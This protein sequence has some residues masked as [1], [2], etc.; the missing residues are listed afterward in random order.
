[1][2][3]EIIKKM[4][5]VTS[6]FIMVIG[7]GSLFVLKNFNS[8]LFEDGTEL[9]GVICGVLFGVLMLIFVM[10]QIMKR[11]WYPV[12]LKKLIAFS[13]KQLRIYHGAISIFGLAF[14]IIHIG[15]AITS[16]GWNFHDFLTKFDSIT[17]YVCTLLMILSVIAGLIV[18]INR[19]VFWKLHVYLA[20]LSVVPFI[21][22]L[23]D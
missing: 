18:K 12:S 15:F 4:I 16:G 7:L 17:G 1:M 10:I 5:Y 3:K 23:I 19:K 14:L 21:I 6:L 13:T 20:F 22:H 2:K 8:E 11:K 9:T